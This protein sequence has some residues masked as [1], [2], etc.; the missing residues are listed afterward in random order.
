MRKVRKSLHECLTATFR[1]SKQ[2]LFSLLEILTTSTS[3]KK[4]LVYRSSYLI[5]VRTPP[6]GNLFCQTLKIRFFLLL[7]SKVFMKHSIIIKLCQTRL[8]HSWPLFSFSKA[9]ELLQ[10]KNNYI[11]ISSLVTLCDRFDSGNWGADKLADICW[12]IIDSQPS[13]ILEM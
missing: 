2:K 6:N 10:L 7:R 13:Q 12:L 3:T 1:N 11:P 9:S 4:K 5:K 8:N